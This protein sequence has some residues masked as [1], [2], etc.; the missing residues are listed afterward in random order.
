MSIKILHFIVIAYP[1]V[2]ENAYEAVFYSVLKSLPFNPF[3]PRIHPKDYTVLPNCS[4][5]FY[6]PDTN[7]TSP[8]PNHTVLAV[9]ISIGIL[10]GVCLVVG[11]LKY[12]VCHKK[13]GVLPQGL[14]VYLVKLYTKTQLS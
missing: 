2:L 1:T 4:L 3:V 12:F 7:Y 5:L 9:S 13:N 8:T 6:L 11:M 14:F 10:V